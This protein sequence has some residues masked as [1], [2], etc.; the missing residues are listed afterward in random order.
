[1][2]G[3]GFL[4]VRAGLVGARGAEEGDDGLA[5]RGGEVHGA[6]VVGDEQFAP[7]E[8]FDE[9]GQRGASGEVFAPVGRGAA[10][11]FR[12]LPVAGATEEGEAE[13]GVVR[14]KLAAEFGKV[15]GGPALVVPARAGIDAE[16][17]GAVARPLG[18]G[19]GG[20]FGARR[21]P[22]ELVMHRDAE[23]AGDGEIPVHGVGL[24]L[25]TRD[26]EVVGEVRAFAFEFEADGEGA[27]RQPREEGA[28]GEALKVNDPVVTR[29]PHRVDLGKAGG[30]VAG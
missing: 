25:R 11:G 18:L 5:Q 6:G 12:E 10:D 2:Q 23:R 26:G 30:P 22:V 20:G 4:A 16:P 24:G 19:E 8:E 7:A 13:P 28:A 1:M 9:L 29:G 3:K 21:Q 14:G 15:R 27:V 17:A